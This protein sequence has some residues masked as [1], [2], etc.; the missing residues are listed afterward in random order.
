MLIDGGTC[1]TV[2]VRQ[3]APEVEAAEEAER[4]TQAD[5]CGAQAHGQGKLCAFVQQ[6][7]GALSTAMSWREKKNAE[8]GHGGST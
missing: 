3:L 5:T 2:C 1:E 7:L 4:L 6:Q 8:W